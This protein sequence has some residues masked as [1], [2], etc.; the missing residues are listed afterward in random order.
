MKKQSSKKIQRER[1]KKKAYEIVD[2]NW[3]GICTGCGVEKPCTHSHIIPISE[4]LNLES[5]PENITHHCMDCHLKWESHNILI[6]NELLDFKK[7][8]KY[9]QKMNL[10]YYNRIFN[11]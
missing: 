2:N 7:N 3:D 9:I 4:D 1:N 8:M 5:E 6:M 10:L 11:K